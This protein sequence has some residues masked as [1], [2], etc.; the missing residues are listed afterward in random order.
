MYARF[1]NWTVLSHPLY[2]PIQ[3]VNWLS[4]AHVKGN[5]NIFHKSNII[6][7]YGKYCKYGRVSSVKLLSYVVTKYK[8]LGPW[9]YL[10][11]QEFVEYYLYTR[12]D[13][14]LCC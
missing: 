10:E 9:C 13:V 14:R 7:F 6:L 2:V 3:Y 4:Y 5:S 8:L 12:I 1:S 11:K